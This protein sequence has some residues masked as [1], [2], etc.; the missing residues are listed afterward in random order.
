MARAPS[1]SAMLDH[2]Y[3]EEI[4]KILSILA[5]SMLG[6]VCCWNLLGGNLKRTRVHD[7][8]G[9]VCL[10]N[11]DLFLNQK[12]VF[13]IGLYL[14]HLKQW[15]FTIHL[16]SH[17]TLQVWVMLGLVLCFLLQIGIYISYDICYIYIIDILYICNMRIHPEVDRISQFQ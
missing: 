16:M 17:L 4:E 14:N 1:R 2:F 3:W 11:G 15:Q 13:W 12:R 10:K 9:D 6:C 8:M 5:K 7:T